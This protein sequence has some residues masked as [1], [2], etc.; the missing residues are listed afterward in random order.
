M[1]KNVGERLRKS[2]LTKIKIEENGCWTWLGAINK[3][4]GYGAMKVEGVYRSAHCVAFF[5]KHGTYPKHN[6]THS[7]DNIRCV[8]W[9]HIEDKTQS[10]NLF[11]SAQRGRLKDRRKRGKSSYK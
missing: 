10:E 2:F 3:R 9:D 7:C 11:D 6:G 5:L 8:N 1:W 4:S